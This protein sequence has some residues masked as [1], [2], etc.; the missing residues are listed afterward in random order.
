[1]GMFRYFA[2]L[3]F[4]WEPLLGF[5]DCL[6]WVSA[7]P[8]VYYFIRDREGGTH[9]EGRI[10][11][12]RISF[13]RIKG[14]S[15]YFGADYLFASGRLK[16]ETA[17]GRSLR[18]ELTDQIV[19]ARLGFTLQ[20]KAPGRPFI[21][22]FGGWGYFKEIN[23]FYPPSP[24]PCTFTDTFNYLTAGF[25]S[26]INF[27]PLLSMGINFKLRFMQEAKSE[28]SDDP[29][30]DDVTL[31]M[32]EEMHVRLDIPFAY[33][34]NNPLRGI[35]FLLSPFYE[36]RH[37]GGREGFP[38]NFRDTKFYLYGARFALIYRF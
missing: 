17:T 28:V 24:I 35:G 15:W 8:E 10:D 34:P 13:D 38:F 2:L 37:F 36:Y 16:G 22:P 21:T 6:Y 27:T 9:Q 25:L 12:V 26:G 4:A 18:S 31:H 33:S 11:G 19:E 5:A 32:K 7:G 14:C 20:Q 29:L 3:I 1:M 30:F 23:D